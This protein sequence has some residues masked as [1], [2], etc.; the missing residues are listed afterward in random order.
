MRFQLLF[1]LLGPALPRKL[2]F[3]S[4][5]FN[6][7][8]PFADRGSASKSIPPS[9]RKPT[10]APWESDSLPYDLTDSGTDVEDSGSR[11]S[12][13]STR[14]QQPSATEEWLMETGQIEYRPTRAYFPI[15]LE[16]LA[17]DATV[18][19]MKDYLQRGFYNATDYQKKVQ[20]QIDGYLGESWPLLKSGIILKSNL[21]PKASTT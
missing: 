4:S 3:L 19:W 5:L 10:D 6:F 12:P 16:R 8:K 15:D 2:N 11:D 20:K 13:A 7:T 14:L 18:T 9:K 21:L 1:L 17:G